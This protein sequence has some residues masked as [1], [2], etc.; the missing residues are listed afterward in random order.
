MNFR[1]IAG[2]IFAMAGWA[3]VSATWQAAIAQLITVSGI[4]LLISGLER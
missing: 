3:I 2:L 1:A 4:Y